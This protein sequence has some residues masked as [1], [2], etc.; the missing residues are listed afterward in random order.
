[1]VYVEE[2]NVGKATYYYL[3]K[4]IREGTRA[5]RKKRKYC[6][7]RKPSTND[8]EEFSAQ[9][10][11][12]LTNYLSIEQQ[13]AIEKIKKG[14]GAYVERLT[15]Q[16]F[17]KFEDATITSFTYNTNAIEGSTLSLN[18]TGIILQEKI[19]PS[20]KELREVYGALN[21]KDAFYYAKKMSDIT[22]K[23][24]K[25]L[26][27]IVLRNILEVE[28]GEYRTVPVRILG[29]MVR[30]P[31]PIDVEKEMKKLITWYE[32]NKHIHPFE[33][34]CI[35]HIKFEKIH[36]F[37][38]GNGRVG[39]LLM[40]YILIK[41]KLPLLDIKVVRKFEYYKTLEKAQTRKK[42]KDFIHYCF[43]AY[44]EDATILDWL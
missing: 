3:V 11:Y 44:K 23:N 32:N 19:T 14:Y 10:E 2:R 6:G 38:D 20:G 4:N 9:Q 28:L 13:R 42:Y 27:S 36:P 34:A 5:W 41:N 12:V 8:I 22:E 29:S 39:R 1:M 31:L 17:I 35:L 7:T 33:L 21:M 18:E 43:S 15:E 24:I 25:K 37:R 16:D 26:H 40:N 30:P